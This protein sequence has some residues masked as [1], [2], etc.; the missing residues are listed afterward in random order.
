MKA[1][2]DLADLSLVYTS[3]H[4][5]PV[6]NQLQESSTFMNSFCKLSH[7][8]HVLATIPKSPPSSLGMWVEISLKIARCHESLE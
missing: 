8:T 5:K 2:W 3:V 1:G 7:G 4:F 6:S